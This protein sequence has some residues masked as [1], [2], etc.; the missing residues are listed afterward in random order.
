MRTP[1]T[2]APTSGDAARAAAASAAGK[3]AESNRRWPAV[4]RVAA[5]LDRVLE[6]NHLG[7]KIQETYRSR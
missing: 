5:A 3:L 6:E 1:P 7:A 4:R 2:E